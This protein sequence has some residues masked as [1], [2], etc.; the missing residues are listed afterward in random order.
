MTGYQ[1]VLVATGATLVEAV[2][3]KGSDNLSIPLSVVLLL[4]LFASI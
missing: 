2:S 4:S 3:G 1:L